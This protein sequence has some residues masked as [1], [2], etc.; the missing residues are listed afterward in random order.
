[1][2]FPIV[3]GTWRWVLYPVL[4]NSGFGVRRPMPEIQVMAV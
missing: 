1:M 4:K 2:I 3:E